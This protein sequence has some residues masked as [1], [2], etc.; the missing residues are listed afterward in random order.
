MRIQDVLRYMQQ[1][2]EKIR[3]NIYAPVMDQTNPRN[4]MFLRQLEKELSM[5]RQLDLPLDDLKVVVFDLETSG[6]HPDRGDEILSIGAVKLEGERI[7]EEEQF[8]S[9]VQSDVNLSQEIVDLTGI[10]EEHIRNAPALD[11]VM[12]EFFR[13]IKKHTLVA[14]H[15]QH[16]LAFMKDA[17]RKLMRGK[18]HHRIIDTSFLIRAVEPDSECVTLDDCCSHCGIEVEDR[19][20]ALGDSITAAKLWS[21]YMKQTKQMGFQ[22]MRDVYS[23]LGRRDSRS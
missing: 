20:H 23:V 21:H 17:M 14:H 16:E 19:H 6:F 2:P 12:V 1:F 8:Y 7:L 18:F 4:V 15:A 13:F 5:E 9:Y 3:S 11:D 10:H 22:T